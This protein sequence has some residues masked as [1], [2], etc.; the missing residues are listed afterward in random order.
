MR[1]L[2]CALIAAGSA[3]AGGRQEIES[4]PLPPTVQP[5]RLT[6]KVGSPDLLGLEFEYLVPGLGNW[7]GAWISG[8][9]LPIGHDQ[10]ETNGVVTELAHGGFTHFGVGA[11]GY[12][13]GGG[14]GA[15]ASIGYD[16]ISCYQDIL[17]TKTGQKG[18]INSTHLASFELGYKY[19]GPFMTCSLFGGYGLNFAYPKVDPAIEK[20]PPFK[21]GNWILAGFSL[22]LAFPFLPG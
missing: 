2:F 11:D 16:R 19:V 6:G 5:Y 18:F 3:F 10:S 1:V 20:D 12:L 17:K 15:F 14:S 21:K 22:G 8:S 9:Y 4:A 13:L 7:L